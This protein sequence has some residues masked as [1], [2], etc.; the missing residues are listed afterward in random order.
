MDRL[1]RQS[2]IANIGGQR[3]IFRRE[4]G[5]WEFR[6]QKMLFDERAQ[7]DQFVKSEYF[8]FL[9]ASEHYLLRSIV[10]FFQIIFSL[11]ALLSIVEIGNIVFFLFRVP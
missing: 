2:Y 7:L 9:R 10:Y 6:K 1:T 3:L 4:R 11:F 5:K 8:N